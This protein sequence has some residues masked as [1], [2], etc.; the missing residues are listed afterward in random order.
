MASGFNRQ[1]KRNTLDRISNLPLEVTAEILKHLPIKEA[2]GT[3]RLSRH[4]RYQWTAIQELKFNDYTAIGQGQTITNT[5][6][7]NLVNS[8]LLLHHHPVTRFEVYTIKA[9][10]SDVDRCLSIFAPD[11]EHCHIE[12]PYQNIKFVHTPKLKKACLSF[13][14][15]DMNNILADLWQFR[16]SPFLKEINVH[17]WQC[18]PRL[19]P[20]E[21]FW[22]KT[23]AVFQHLQKV[24]FVQFREGQNELQ[25][26]EFF[27]HKATILQT[28]NITRMQPAHFNEWKKLLQFPRTSPEARINII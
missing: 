15:E 22:K 24:N 10:S 21:H 6:L 28:I 18:P 2:V 12:G 3:S 16:N 5:N 1:E 27:L 23:D 8:V 14:S 7:T 20:P 9:P 25:L 19:V 4:W 26:I 11:L 13:N 17:A